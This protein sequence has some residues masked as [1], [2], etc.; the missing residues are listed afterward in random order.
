MRE[1]E[2]G[3]RELCNKEWRIKLFW[4]LQVLMGSE[5]LGG[6]KG[7]TRPGWSAWGHCRKH[8]GAGHQRRADTDRGDEATEE[9]SETMSKTSSKTQSANAYAYWF[10]VQ[11]PWFHNYSWYFL[12]ELGSNIFV[13]GDMKTKSMLWNN[14]TL[15]VLVGIHVI[16]ED[17]CHQC[18][19]RNQSKCHLWNR[20]KFT[21]LALSQ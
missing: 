10:V 19:R 3:E 13:F 1:R 12:H 18:F 5:V 8:T 16:L 6:A 20:G 17:F 2:R 7:A 4:S 11:F 21:E 15:W 14:A 9:K